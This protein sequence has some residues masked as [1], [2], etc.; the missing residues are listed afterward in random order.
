VRE[1]WIAPLARRDVAGILVWSGDQFG[2]SVRARYRRLIE[3]AIRDVALDPE[4]L[5]SRACPEVGEGYRTYHLALSRERARDAS[6]LIRR[7]RHLL[8]YRLLADDRL[9]IGRVLHDAM[10]LGRHLADDAPDSD[11]D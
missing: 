9:E 4:R 3:V 2:A 10:D 5:G 1:V 7:P 8:L 6:G 11:D